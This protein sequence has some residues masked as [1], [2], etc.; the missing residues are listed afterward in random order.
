M[1][2]VEL[3]ASY[4]LVTKKLWE[5]LGQ[6]EEPNGSIDKLDLTISRH[7]LAEESHHQSIV[8]STIRQEMRLCYG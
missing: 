1:L 5:V 8:Q 3:M 7:P 4:V 2:A 6:F